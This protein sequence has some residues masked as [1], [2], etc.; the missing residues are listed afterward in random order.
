MSGGP[1]LVGAEGVV[2]LQDEQNYGASRPLM[3]GLALVMQMR[4]HPTTRTTMMVNQVE[5]GMAEHWMQIHGLTGV[6][7]KGIVPEDK[8]EDP[9]L[10]QWYV[11][12]RARSAG[13]IHLVITA[14]AE[15]F[16]RCVDS[17]QPVMLYGRR[18]SLGT[19]QEIRPTWDQLHAKVIRHREAEVETMDHDDR[20]E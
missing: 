20:F 1:L 7:V 3:E 2:M 6:G 14:Y 8:E 4:H 12:E 11:V 19:D 17:H 5:T 10:A 16:Q 9:G 18:G 15:V 13:P